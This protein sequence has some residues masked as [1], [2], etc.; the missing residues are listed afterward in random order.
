M[1]KENNKL[2]ELDKET[3]MYQYHDLV[4]V[5]Y[6]GILIALFIT[7][8]IISGLDFERKGNKI[9]QT[10]VLL[11]MVWYSFDFVLKY[12]DGVNSVFVWIHHTCTILSMLVLYQSEKT[13]CFGATALFTNDCIHI[14]LVIYRTFERMNFPFDHYKYKINFILLTL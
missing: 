3:M 1:K 2:V 12:L 4:S 13:L 8:C 9:E 14:F 10:I 6:S 7:N 11:G 5:I